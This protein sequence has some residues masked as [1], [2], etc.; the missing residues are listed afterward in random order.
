ME[1]IVCKFYD[2]DIDK[3]Y[4][5]I[6]INRRVH[7]LDDKNNPVDIRDINYGFVY[8]ELQSYLIDE[9]NFDKVGEDKT[10]Y[11]WGYFYK[12]NGKIAIPAMYDEAF[13]FE[14]GLASIKLDDKY[15]FI[16]Y[17]GV[18]VIEPIYEY[19]DMYFRGGLCLAK[20]DGK[21]GY[22]N[23]DGKVKIDF[24][25][26]FAT[27]FL[28][29][30]INGGKERF[31]AIIKEE[32]RY[33]IIDIDGNYIIEP[34]YEELRQT[35]FEDMLVAKL[36]GKYALIKVNY[37]EELKK[38]VA[39]YMVEHIFDEVGSMVW[40]KKIK[41][42]NYFYTMKMDKHICLIDRGLK[43]YFSEVN[44]RKIEYKESSIEV[45]E[46]VFLKENNLRYRKFRGENFL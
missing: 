10:H 30:D 38:E 4:D 32:T 13:P 28:V 36:E 43:L 14:D 12:K 17:L 2:F 46:D 7:F 24:K 23:I 31:Y 45:S 18:E 27:E 15:G 22:I 41:G 25:F 20:K 16:N 3:Y 21:F 40:T 1:K 39:K 33:G 19:T 26:N 37:N 35:F 34:I 5:G 9:E 44:E 8:D 29:S 6:I 11:K 42:G